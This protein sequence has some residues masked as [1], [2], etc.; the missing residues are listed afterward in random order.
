[1]FAGVVLAIVFF[2][3]GSLLGSD[4]VASEDPTAGVVG[5]FMQAFGGAFA[6]LLLLWGLLVV[7]SGRWIAQGRNRTGSMVIAALCCISFPFGAALG[8]FTLIVL[9][10]DEVKNGYNAIR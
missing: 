3:I 10:D 9:S 6:I 5:R 8:I 4:L 7:L 2:S 1:M